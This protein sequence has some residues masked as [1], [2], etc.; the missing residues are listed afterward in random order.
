MFWKY[1]TNSSQLDAL[2]AKE[3]VT[4]QE[5]METD[6]IINECR[7][8][9]KLL[10]DF[11]QKTEVMEELVTL[12]TKEPSID[13]EE[14]SRFKYPNIACE[15]LTCDVPALNERL[16]RDEV[17]LDKLYSF[18]ECDPPLNP[19]LASYFS[20]VMGALIAKK[21]EQNW[22]SYQFTCLQVLDFL[23]A[24]DT[25]ISLLLKHLGTSAI[26]DLMLKLMTQVEGVE[27]NQNILNWLDSKRIIQSLISLLSPKVDRERHY[28]V[29]QLLCDF[30]R[31]SRD[32]QKH[33]VERVDPDPLLNTLES[34]ETV[35]LLLDYIL[36]GDEKSETA[37]V[38]GIQVLLSLLDA[39]P[40]NVMKFSSTQTL[41][42]STINDEPCDSEQKQRSIFSTTQVIKDRIRDFHDLLLDPPK[43]DPVLTTVGNLSPPL[44]NTRLQVTRLFA[45][46]IAS[47]NKE[48]LKNVE[49]TD[50]FSVLLDLFF[51]YQWNNFLHTQV[52]NC[53][54]AALKTHSTE[55][56]DENSNALS[57]HLLLKCKVI[58][59]II[60]AWKENDEQQSQEK[61]IR[62][63]YMGHLISIMNKIVDLCNN[64]LGQYLKDNLP[65]VAKSLDEFKENTLA[66]T[67]S[68]QRCLLAD[69]HP[70]SSA[71]DPDNYDN[72]P[73][74][75][76]GPL[77]QQMYFQYQMQNLTPQIIEG[78]SGFNDDAFNDGDSILQSTDQRRAIYHRGELNFDLPEE[79]FQHIEVFKQVCAQSINTLDDAD[80]QIFDDRE[81]TFQTVIEKNDKNNLIY[82]SDSDEELPAGDDNM[83]VDP[84]TSPKPSDQGAPSFPSG[85]PWNA[86]CSTPPS[87]DN[88]VG[89]WAD[90][91]SA[92]FEANFSGQNENSARGSKDKEGSRSRVVPIV[93]EKDL[94]VENV[95]ADEEKESAKNCAEGVAQLDMCNTKSA[96]GDQGD[97]PVEDIESGKTV[98]SNATVEPSKSIAGDTSLTTA[99]ANPETPEQ[100][101]KV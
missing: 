11:L 93:M 31:I 78:Y 100:D 70:N 37:I 97:I 62:K 8:Q 90:F 98:E 41:Y 23:K 48:L 42:G 84:W 19:L 59:R 66:E 17:L 30:V 1:N 10:I 89:G 47:N 91:S 20:K 14:K 73:F 46:L 69:A 58:E 29:A 22:L 54:I 7:V 26:M 81:H 43:Q 45:V 65:D 6:D 24:K 68:V 82:S 85:D 5:V 92:Q 50:T 95:D 16:A 63:G 34:Q 33:S 2:L 55:E 15:L 88:T 83:D 94:K 57:K 67:N 39:C 60:T 35:S 38:G 21:T 25:F 44:G 3:D 36:L 99:P 4:L 40:S 27:M 9:N 76:N 74:S 75:Q 80:D 86:N 18:L 32:N 28:N 96:A 87:D 61:G 12:I 77:L 53:L 52:E 101:K 64:S 13:I 79:D 51:K 72:L 56:K 71:E 49:A